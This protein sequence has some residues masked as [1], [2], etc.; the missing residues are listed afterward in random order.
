MVTHIDVDLSF[1]QAKLKAFGFAFKQREGVA[2]VSTRVHYR[3]DH[4]S[5]QVLS[6]WVSI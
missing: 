1:F 3:N 2:A 4:L 5:V 6:G